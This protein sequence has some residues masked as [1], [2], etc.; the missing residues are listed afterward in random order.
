[1][2]RARLLAD[3]NRRLLEAYS[4]RTTAALRARLPL[5][6]ALPWLDDLL[7]LNV[8]KEVRKDALVI[9]HAVQ[10]VRAGQPVDDAL[11]SV[12]LQAAREI[13]RDFLARARGPLEIPLRPEII[14]PVRRRRIRRMLDATAQL[15]GAWTPRCKLRAALAQRFPGGALER[16]LFELMRDYADETRLLGESVRMP[17]LLAPLRRRVLAGLFETM[18]QTAAGLA[19]EASA[20][21]MAGSGRGKASF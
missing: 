18:E 16:L 14:E 1:M 6:L 9:R 11:V 5:P 4:R 19:R 7:L 15:C 8:D 13:D 12:L 2:R 21:I 10:T 17:A 20:R 3:L